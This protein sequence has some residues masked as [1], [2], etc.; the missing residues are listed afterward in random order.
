M[1]KRMAAV[2]VTFGALAGCAAPPTN[3][4]RQDTSEQQFGKDKAECRFESVK[5]ANQRDT[6]YRSMLGQELELANRRGEVFDACMEA[7]GYNRRR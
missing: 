2:I 6:S 1:M 3:W 4:V 5:A 7:K